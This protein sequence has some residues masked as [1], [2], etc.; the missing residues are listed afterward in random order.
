[1]P[2]LLG[3]EVKIM[4]NKETAMQ[5]FNLKMENLVLWKKKQ[6]YGGLLWSLKQALE[7]NDIELVKVLLNSW[8]DKD[9]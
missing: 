9:H 5:L 4:T 8:V 1:M 2:R 3:K 6:E 7:D